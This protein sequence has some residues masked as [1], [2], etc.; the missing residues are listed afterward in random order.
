MTPSSR[1]FVGARDRFLVRTARHV[2]SNAE[3]DVEIDD[4]WVDQQ[5]ALVGATRAEYDEVYDI[6]SENPVAHVENDSTADLS[7][8]EVEDAVLAAVRRERETA[9]RTNSLLADLLRREDADWDAVAVLAGVP[10]ETLRTRA[11]RDPES[12]YS[13]TGYVTI[14]EAATMLNIA[15]STIHRRIKDGK[16]KPVQVRGRDMIPLDEKGVPVV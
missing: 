12:A 7:T 10:V 2:L 11:G 14:S 6:L 15:R 5:L 13:A 1:R 3:H 8:A 16:T 9:A 4:A